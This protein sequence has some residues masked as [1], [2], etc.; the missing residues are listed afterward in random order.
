[1]VSLPLAVNIN[2]A[3]IP[4]PISAAHAEAEIINF[5]STAKSIQKFNKSSVIFMQ[6]PL[7]SPEYL[8]VPHVIE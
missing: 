4:I 3:A 1:M 7:L 8:P 5:K 6:L 2:M